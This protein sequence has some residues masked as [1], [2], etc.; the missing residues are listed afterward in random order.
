[1]FLM[2]KT[3]EEIFNQIFEIANNFKKDEE[4]YLLAYKYFL[5]YFQ[6]VDNIQ[7]DNIVIGISFTYS[8]MPT[9]LKKIDLT[10]P[11]K[12]VLIFN[13]VKDDEILT[14][15]EFLILKNSFNNSIVGTS[16]LLHFINPEKYAIWDSRVVRFL[17]GK[18]SHNSK[19]Q[20]P[21][22]YLEYLTLIEMLKKD[23]KF[24][25][26]YELMIQKVGYEISESRALELA[27]FKGG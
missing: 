26:F 16:K 19:F 15:Q 6:E 23:T 22:T 17:T 1:M 11:E 4:N 8:W 27:F 10:N 18:E 13:K 20:D 21:K 7:L 9:I 12:L 25:N 2:L 3:H 24:H 14:T 5:N